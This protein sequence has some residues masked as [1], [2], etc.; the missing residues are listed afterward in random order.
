MQETSV[1]AFKEIQEDGTLGKQQ[2]AVIDCLGGGFSF[3]ASEIEARTNLRAHKRMREL[4]RIGRIEEAGQ[5]KCFV[6]GKQ[7]ITWKLSNEDENGQ[8]RLL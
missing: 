2:Q 7:A 8:Q 1:K 6:T 5:R 3:T 4:A